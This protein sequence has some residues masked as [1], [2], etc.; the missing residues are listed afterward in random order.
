[1]NWSRR[2]R[3]LQTCWF[4]LQRAHPRCSAPIT[5]YFRSTCAECGTLSVGRWHQR[6]CVWMSCRG[7]RW[8]Q[9]QS[10][11][12]TTVAA[13]ILMPTSSEAD[14]VSH[15]ASGNGALSGGKTHFLLSSLV[16]IHSAFTVKLDCCDTRNN[17]LRC[18]LTF[19]Y[20]YVYLRPSEAHMWTF[21]P[22]HHHRF[23]EIV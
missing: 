19:A 14:I 18:L 17:C 4:F 15:H 2:Q 13:V 3:P 7:L 23:D 9:T 11:F 1:M 22:I 16:L 20:L 10:E 12:S 21:C 8:E 6:V 5:R